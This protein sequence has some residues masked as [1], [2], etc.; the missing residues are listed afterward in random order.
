MI[1]WPWKPRHVGPPDESTQ[2]RREA[3]A[4]ASRKLRRAQT[5]AARLRAADQE[6]HYSQRLRLSY[7]NAPQEGRS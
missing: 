1:R 5:L 7:A 4:I 2:D 6:N 3:I